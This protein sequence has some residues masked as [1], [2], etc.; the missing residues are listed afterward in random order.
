MT[1]LADRLGI[2]AK[3][4]PLIARA[5]ALGLTTVSS[6]ETLAVARGCWH[7]H[8]P[9]MTTAK[10]VDEAQFSNEELAIILLSPN[11]P[12][13]P[14]TLRL[15]AA[16]LGAV[17]ND[18]DKLADLARQE[19]A[20]VSVLYVAH[21]ALQFEPNHPLWQALI[22]KIPPAAQ[23]KGGVFPHPTRFVSMTGITRAGLGRIT[24]WIRPHVA[25][26]LA[27]G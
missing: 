21:A 15:G 22:E 4:S 1:T 17:G 24:V 11:Q 2:P 27:H 7:Y 3:P 19:G 6:L 10:A 13:S 20:E 14:N 9:N 25:A 5:K 18:P 23:P 16:M 12:Y 8:Q 26:A